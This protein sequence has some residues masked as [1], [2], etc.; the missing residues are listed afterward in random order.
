M[1]VEK[2]VARRRILGLDVPDPHSLEQHQQQPTNAEQPAAAAAGRKRRRGAEASDP[3][4]TQ[5]LAADA[6]AGEGSGSDGEDDG[7]GPES[8]AEAAAAE[9]Q[10][11]LSSVL[12]SQQ[13]PQ[14]GLQD[15]QAAVNAVLTGAVARLV[16][17][18]ALKAAAAAASKGGTIS[19]NYLK[20]QLSTSSSSSSS[21]LEFRAGFL[22]VLG[23]YTSPGVAQLQREIIDSIRQAFP[24][25][26]QASAALGTLF[27]LYTLY[28]NSHSRDVAS[29]LCPTLS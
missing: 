20:P 23:R 18:Q 8:D 3:Q 21:S 22:R 2:L 4:A 9:G 27:I 19:S 10:P 6:G 7:E 15:A 25:V 5:Q 1:Y 26:S 16:Y 13:Q 28:W 17:Q 24:T 12:A 29:L 14:D 11:S